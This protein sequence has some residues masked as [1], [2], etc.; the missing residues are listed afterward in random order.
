[1]SGSTPLDNPKHER[2]AQL[3]A[4]TGN[5]S[6]CYRKAGYSAKDADTAGH[7]LS[8]N[9]RIRARVAFLKVEAAK[10]TRIGKERLLEILSDAVEGKV[11]IDSNRLK[12]GEMLAKMCGWN[13]PE[14]V[15]GKMEIVIRKL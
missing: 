15:D 5:A 8:V 12:A 4:V 2:F 10:T 1:M 14:Q 7:R 3:Y 9:V 6:M 13:E 11:E